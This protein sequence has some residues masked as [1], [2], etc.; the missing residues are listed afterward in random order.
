MRFSF[1]DEQ[2]QFRDFVRKFMEANS[3]ATEVRRL[4]QT[5]DGY[6]KGVWQNLSD[7]LGLAGLHIP[8]Q[9]GGQGFGPVELGI[10]LEEMGRTLLCA[11][12]FGSS[13][14]ATT[15]ILQAGSDAD[16]ERLL[17]ELA[18]G[19]QL[20]ALA[21]AEPNGLWSASGI[22]M[23]ATPGS[24]R[25]VLNGV[26][27]FVLDG[28]VADQIVV[29]ARL[30]DSA[31]D[32]GISFFTVK[33]AAPGLDKRL[34]STIDETRKLSLLTFR[35]VEAEPLGDV[36]NAGAALQRVLNLSYIALANEMV[37]GAQKLFENAIDYAKLRVQFGRTIG[38]FQAIKHKCAD[39]LLDVE[40]AKSAAYY[41]A[42]AASE[43][44]EDLMAIA[45]LAKAC[46]SDTYLRVA[47]ATIQIHGGIGFTWENDTHLYFKRAKSSEV[48][49]GGPEA[50][51][52]NLVQ[53]W[54]QL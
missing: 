45:S 31:A 28:L 1:T 51:R 6:D 7:S 35:D 44:A 34:L 24:G 49:L 18:A 46:A 15:A 22:E 36:G 26:K 30:P 29:V 13:V 9:Y 2:Q 3:A 40:L 43:G 11:P 37:G 21:L 19:E 10:A 5:E 48:M 25:F 41:A 42:E 54:G 47:A 50:H 32:E 4:M 33:S 16:K 12:Y 38:S 27:S 8:E 39:L 52:E 53:H 14:L 20:A 23:I 17:P